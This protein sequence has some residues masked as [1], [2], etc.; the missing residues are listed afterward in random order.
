[1]MTPEQIVQVDHVIDLLRPD[2]AGAQ[3]VQPLLVVDHFVA[4]IEGVLQ[5]PA[6]VVQP[7]GL[8]QLFVQSPGQARDAAGRTAYRRGIRPVGGV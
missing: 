4:G 5:Q 2:L 7:G 6:V 1:M 3:A 8:Q